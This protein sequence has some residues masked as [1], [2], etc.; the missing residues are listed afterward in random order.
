MKTNDVLFQ[1]ERGRYQAEVYFCIGKARR[2]GKRRK[3]SGAKDG[4]SFN[5]RRSPRGEFTVYRRNNLVD[6]ETFSGKMSLSYQTARVKIRGERREGKEKNLV[7]TNISK[8]VTIFSR[9]C[10]NLVTGRGYAG[11]FTEVQRHRIR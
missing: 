5:P 6:Q 9:L 10:E 4:R 11:H 3:E 1:V 8:R 2:G 7:N